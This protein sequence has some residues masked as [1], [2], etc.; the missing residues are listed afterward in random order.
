MAAQLIRDQDRALR[1]SIALRKL[2]RN[3]DALKLLL[4]SGIDSEELTTH[5]DNYSWFPQLSVR[6]V[7]KFLQVAALGCAVFQEAWRAR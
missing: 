3:T 5:V 2:G 4:T 6:F 1:R 7:R